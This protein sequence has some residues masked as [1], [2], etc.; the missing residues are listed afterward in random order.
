MNAQIIIVANCEKNNFS[1]FLSHSWHLTFFLKW[2][3]HHMALKS[4]FKV[5]IWKVA[6]HKH[7]DTDS[8]WT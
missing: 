7:A 5:D 3:W 1:I 4:I 2:N 6:K 8:I